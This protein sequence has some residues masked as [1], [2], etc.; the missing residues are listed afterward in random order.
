MLQK[1]TTSPQLFQVLIELMDIP[2]LTKFRLGGGT[3]LSLMRGHRKSV[4]ID[5][6]TDEEYGKLILIL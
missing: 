3:A 2:E 1:Q 4:D 6:F 5:L